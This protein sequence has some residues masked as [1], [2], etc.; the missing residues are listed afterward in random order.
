MIK[1]KYFLLLIFSV[2][3]IVANLLTQRLILLIN[4]SNLFLLIAIFLGTLVGLL[5]KFYLDKRWIFF[6][7]SFGII[8]QAR[9]FSLYST[10]G[11]FTTIFFWITETIFWL[12]WKNHNMREL[13]ALIGLSI[14]YIIK[15]NLDKSFVFKKR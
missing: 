7:K 5:I 12:I 14:G 3:A 15:Y 1:K 10:M 8:S 4:K 11:I 2:L 9:T 13:G 6:D